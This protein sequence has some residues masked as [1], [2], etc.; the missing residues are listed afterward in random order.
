MSPSIAM[1]HGPSLTLPPIRKRASYFKAL[2]AFAF[3]AVFSAATAIAQETPPESEG[4]EP[5]AEAPVLE[6]DVLT[7]KS[8]T[9]ISGHQV[10]R[11]DPLFYYVE[12][13]EGIEPLEVPRSQV[14]SVEYDNR[15]PLRERRRS[16]ISL[17]GPKESIMS[18]EKLSP[19]LM[20][21]LST[22]ISQASLKVSGRDFVALLE[23]MAGRV[24][25][26]IK[27]HDS[28]RALPESERKWTLE[29][30][31]KPTL[32]SLLQDHLLKQFDG[33]EIDFTFDAILVTTKESVGQ[34]EAPPAPQA[35]RKGPPGPARGP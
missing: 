19:E 17:E 9:V 14:V 30:A 5:D 28:V 27:I 4:Q 33:L 24:G 16:S 8:G 35:P 18:G 1:I 34:E 22:P 7:L 29:T 2:S 3:M 26:N 23:E 10:L 21:K 15:D 11:S 12:I 32:M 13:V 25:A 20:E 6:G 31:P